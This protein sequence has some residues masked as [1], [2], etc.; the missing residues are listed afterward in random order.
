MNQTTLKV[1]S[2]AF[3]HGTTIPASYTCDGKNVNPPLNLEGLPA[4]T[5]YL[6]IILDD[7]DAPNGT[8]T[9]WIVWD[10]P[11]TA[12]IEENSKPTGITGRND[13]GKNN[14]MGPCPP[15]GEEHRYFIK[16]YAL[17]DKLGLT[18]D[19]TKEVLEKQLNEKSV[20]SGEL[21]GKYKRQRA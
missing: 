3:E 8:F 7:P 10:M 4:N 12:S 11:S 20:A 17:T 16:I 6:A 14:Y 2:S 15:N 19:T 5:E 9:H 13:F 1:T 18:A 21:M